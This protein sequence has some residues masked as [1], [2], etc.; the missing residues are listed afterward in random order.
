MVPAGIV[1]LVNKR[2]R[3][4]ES[5][6]SST[7]TFTQAMNRLGCEVGEYG[8][9]RSGGGM[10][11]ATHME[12]VVYVDRVPVCRK[13]HNVAL[14]ICGHAICKGKSCCLLGP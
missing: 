13:A 11:C 9:A 5:D 7:A 8:R 14:G 10:F 12:N 4:R 3:H 2:T 6:M 1:L